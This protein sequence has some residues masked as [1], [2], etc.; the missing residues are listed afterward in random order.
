[1]QDNVLQQVFDDHGTKIFEYLGTK[2]VAISFSSYVENYT[3]KFVR[4]HTKN[5]VQSGGE[6]YGVTIYQ[7]Y[8]TSSGEC[9]FITDLNFCEI[10]NL[11]LVKVVTPFTAERSYDFVVTRA[12]EAEKVF[13]AISE[14]QRVKNFKFDDTLPV[15]GLDFS[16]LKRYTIDFLKDEAFREYCT[17]HRIKHKFGA[18]FEGYPGTG[19]SM[20]L[21]WLKNQCL[22]ENIGFRVFTDMEDFEERKSEFYREGPQIFVFEEFDA[23]LRERKDSGYRDI[24]GVLSHMLNLLDGINE[25]DNVVVIFTTNHVQT[26]DRAMLRPGRIDKVFSFQLPT[27]EQRDA[28]V[29]LYIEDAAVV[30]AFQRIINEKAKSAQSNISYALLKGIVDEYHIT[31]FHNVGIVEADFEKIV[32]DKILAANKNQTEAKRATLA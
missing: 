19:K 18:I 6:E 20:S 10:S 17:K 27:Q 7:D 25:I 5:K 4:Q 23:A 2:D 21:K 32:N 31:K 16:E 24:N 22:K 26:F 8:S 9:R 12:D 13:D 14:E 15:V 3:H 29:Q 1:M 30:E 11:K 28:F